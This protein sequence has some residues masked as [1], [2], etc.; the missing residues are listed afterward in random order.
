MT[1][2]LFQ[3]YHHFPANVAI[4]AQYLISVSIWT[5]SVENNIL[6]DKSHALLTFRNRRKKEH[7][8]LHQ[9]SSFKFQVGL[10]G[11]KI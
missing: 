7:L 5:Y 11:Q 10:F 4:L 6:I 1:I 9:V 8:V 3:K 2:V